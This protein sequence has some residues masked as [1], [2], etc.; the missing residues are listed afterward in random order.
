MVSGSDV[1]VSE[2]ID[3]DEPFVAIG[4]KSCSVTSDAFICNLVL[5]PQYGYA[6]LLT[7]DYSKGLTG[8]INRFYPYFNSTFTNEI[9][10]KD[11]LF[12]IVVSGPYGL[13]TVNYMFA[14]KQMEPIYNLGVF[15]S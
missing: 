4:I 5:A 10:V 14:D 15:K 11:T 2:H 6:Y 8:I 9:Y 13:L 7:W 3:D 12:E 1:F